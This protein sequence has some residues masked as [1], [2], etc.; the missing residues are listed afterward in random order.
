MFDI[1]NFI[2]NK[3]LR[4][5]HEAGAMRSFVESYQRGNISDAQVSAW[6]MAVCLNGLSNEN[7]LEFTE[8]LSAS[9]QL[10]TFPFNAVDKHSTGGVGDKLTLL[11]VPMA[12]ACGAKV[13]KLSGRGLGFTGGT[14]D[15]LEA[16]PGFN[17]A[18][19]AEKFIEQVKE[20]GCAVS[21]HSVDLAPA[22]AKFY[23][24]RDATSTLES[25]PL[26]ASSIVSKKVAGGANSI[27]FDVKCGAGAFMKNIAEARALAEA[28]VSLSKLMKRRAAAMI[29]DMNQPLGVNVGN[30]LEILEAIETL[31]G[32]GPADVRSLAV[33][34]A[35]AM[36]YLSFE[37]M[38]LGKG[39]D[40]AEESIKNG[41]ALKKFRELIAA[42][43]G[44]DDVC[45]NP[46]KYLRTAPLYGVIEAVNEGFVSSVDTRGIGEGVKR[47]GGGRVQKGDAV[48]VEVGVRVLKKI[49]DKVS[50]GE[51]LL[52][53]YAND[54]TKALQAME[55]F[56]AFT[57]ED[58]F[59]ESGSCLV[60]EGVE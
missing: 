5:N 53:I 37:N 55:Y 42:Q 47:I 56:D 39:K 26:I 12:A 54:E 23:S 15:K 38:T 46:Q 36:I 1:L 28:L 25:I 51:P 24:L 58:K 27:V 4:R 57:I 44:I 22:E 41:S 16:I 52:E 59:T 19:S 50:K 18:L 10:V 3:R 6:L 13:A 14:V 20:I 17:V 11:V 21:G 29:T 9:G 31:K 49:G 45:E 60:F 7:L 30:S 34:C 48:D 2:D 43:G 33:N 8:A 35:G 32:G 40:L